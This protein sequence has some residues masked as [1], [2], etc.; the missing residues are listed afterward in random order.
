MEPIIL[1]ED[2]VYKIIA[3]SFAPMK[4]WK[5]KSHPPGDFAKALALMSKEHFKITSHGISHNTKLGNCYQNLL[6]AIGEKNATLECSL[7]KRPKGKVKDLIIT[8]VVT[9]YNHEDGQPTKEET[10]YRIYV[11]SQ[12][13]SKNFAGFKD[14]RNNAA[15]RNQSI[16]IIAVV[17]GEDKKKPEGRGFWIEGPALYRFLTST[18]IALTNGDPTLYAK[19]IRALEKFGMKLR[20]NN[21]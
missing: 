13:F 14:T 1:N 7:E 2:E 8:H 18:D 4:N 10:F 12:W 20:K 19:I 9:T 3:K 17:Q 15:G 21:P 6:Y 16:P 5:K 11:Q